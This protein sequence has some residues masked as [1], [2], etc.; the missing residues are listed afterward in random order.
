MNVCVSPKKE[1]NLLTL[2]QF[3]SPGFCQSELMCGVNGGTGGSLAGS[4]WKSRRVY[5]C[6]SRTLVGEYGAAS[7]SSRATCSCSWTIYSPLW[8]LDSAQAH[9]LGLILVAF[10]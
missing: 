1:P 10:K 8:E 9:F 5:N 6:V 7:R 4:L 2:A 3:I